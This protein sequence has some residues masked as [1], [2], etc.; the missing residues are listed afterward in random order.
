MSKPQQSDT[1]LWFEAVAP[2]NPTATIVFLS[3]L[4]LRSRWQKQVAVFRETY[5]CL[6]I[7]LPGNGES[8]QVNDHP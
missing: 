3:R 5:H 6:L 8:Y 1:T 7:D 2:A 4:G